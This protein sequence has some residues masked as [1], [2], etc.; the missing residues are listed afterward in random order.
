METKGVGLED[1]RVLVSRKN[2]RPGLD[3]DP[4]MD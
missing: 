3:R 4:V 1:E 2:N